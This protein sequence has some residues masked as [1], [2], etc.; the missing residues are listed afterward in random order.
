MVL[1]IITSSVIG[2]DTS[3]HFLGRLDAYHF[4]DVGSGEPNKDELTRLGILLHNSIVF[5]LPVHSFDD[6]GWDFLITKFNDFPALKVLGLDVRS[7][8]T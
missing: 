2:D 5:G 7:V 8:Y 1:H 3:P 6:V 4:V